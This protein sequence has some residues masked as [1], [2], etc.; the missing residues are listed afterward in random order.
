MQKRAKLR[1]TN[2]SLF[3]IRL[4]MELCVESDL[5]MSM[6]NFKNFGF[7]IG[8]DNTA[9]IVLVHTII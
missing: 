7:E 1:D 5:S 8:L 3:Y 6:P 9:T 4:W 2:D